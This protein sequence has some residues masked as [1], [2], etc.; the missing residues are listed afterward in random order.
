MITDCDDVVCVGAAMLYRGNHAVYTP[1]SLSLSM[2]VCEYSSD[3]THLKA[4]IKRQHS[5]AGRPNLL[6]GY[7]SQAPQFMLEAF[8]QIAICTRH[9][10]SDDDM[11]W[12]VRIPAPLMRP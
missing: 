7:F 1:N 8:G 2:T 4:S 6:Y 5:F 10:F 11:V 3:S 12:P 9:S